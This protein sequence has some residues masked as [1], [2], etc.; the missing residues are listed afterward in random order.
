MPRHRTSTTFKK[1]DG[2]KK[3]RP[4]GVQDALDRECKEMINDCFHKVGGLDGLVKWAQK[5]DE[6][7]T[8]FYTRMYI[9]LL[10]INVTVK[11]NKDAVYETLEATAPMSIC[12]A[13]SRA[14]RPTPRFSVTPASAKASGCAIRA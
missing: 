9:R 11:A 4:Q 14:A 6:H 2:R 1:G 8:A 12:N 5:S 13:R 3:G 10:P 7:L